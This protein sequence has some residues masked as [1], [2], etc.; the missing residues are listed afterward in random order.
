MP[1]ANSGLNCNTNLPSRAAKGRTQTIMRQYFP[2][3]LAVTMLAAAQFA[4]AQTPAPDYPV[5]LFRSVDTKATTPEPIRGPVRVLVDDGFPPFHYRDDNNRLVG[6]NI[7]IANAV[8]SEL[9]MRCETRVAPFAEL[10]PALA[11]NEA[12]VV[13][14]ALRLGPQALA[15]AEP[16]RPFYRALGHF[17]TT[18]GSPFTS[19][20]PQSLAGRRIGVRSGTAHEAWL[21]RYY[22]D[23][24]IV[25]FA[26]EETAESALQKGNV[27]VVFDDAI[28]L[29]YWI[30]GEAAR[31]CCKLLDG[32]YVDPAYFSQPLSLLVHRGR[33]DNLRDAIDWA[34]DRLQTNGTFA[35]LFRRY[36]PLDPWASAS[37][38]QPTASSKAP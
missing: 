11:R 31:G 35:T 12:D 28:K 33:T 13:V 26:A 34:L 17:A 5:P 16:T 1:E 9:R 10:L 24:E 29:I 21:K 7:E 4:S 18:N 14:S 8:C 38:S 25:P 23:S 2:A 19:A 36:V 15:N 6:L 27:D 30:K 20:S 3:F 22:T 32:G 37:A